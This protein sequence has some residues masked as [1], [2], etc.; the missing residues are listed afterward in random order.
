[1]KDFFPSQSSNGDRIL[2]VDDSFDNLCL[3]QAILESAGYQVSLA[4]NGPSALAQIEASPPQLVISDVM[5][6]GMDGNELTWRI[7]QQENFPFIPIL[8]LTAQDQA[9]VVEGL[10]AG[11]DDFIRKPVLV[12]ELLARVRALLRLKHSVDERE[13]MA[14]LREDFVSRLTHDLRTPL[15]A[16]DRALM[17]LQ[18][19]TFGEISSETEE[20]LATVR[21]NNQNLLQMTNTML[22]VYRYE[23][24][25]KNLT[26]LRFDLPELIEE[27]LQELAPLAEDKGIALNFEPE[28]SRDSNAEDREVVGARLELRRVLTNLVS[29]GIKFT[30]S[31]CVTIRLQRNAEVVKLE[32]QDTGSGISTEDQ[33]M[34]FERFRQGSHRRSE[35]GLGLYLARQ[36]V[37]AHQGT[38][39]V[40]SELGQGSLFTVRLPVHTNQPRRQKK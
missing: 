22:Q 21:A 12:D 26:F 20:V 4:E 8:L 36:I 25:Q 7:R 16:A 17:L 1:M 37:E 31:G 19:G 34:L 39:E 3:I 10:D 38:I 27:V 33:A 29:N 35:I 32:V 5:M 9:D 11:A 30:D 14:R 40:T 18:Q 6:P 28:K 2:A 15:M 23:A 24:G 13:Q